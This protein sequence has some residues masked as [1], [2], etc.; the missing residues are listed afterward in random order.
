MNAKWKSI[1]VV[2]CRL[3]SLLTIFVI[4]SACRPS[5]TDNP[6]WAMS[7]ASRDSMAF[8]RKHHYTIGYNFLSITD[9]LFLYSYI[10]SSTSALATLSQSSLTVIKK[11]EKLVVLEIAR[12]KNDSTYWIKL[13]RD[14]ES[15]GWTPENTLLTS[16]TPCDPVSKLIFVISRYRV[17]LF[18]T[19][20]LLLLFLYSIHFLKHKHNYI[21]HFH[22]IDSIYP[23]L[24]C[25]L[26]ATTGC[27][28]GYMHAYLPDMSREFYFHPTL[29]PFSCPIP[30]CILIILLW[31][32]PIMTIAAIDDACHQLQHK[33]L[34]F[35]ITSLLYTGFALYLLFLHAAGLYHGYVLLPIYVLYALHRYRFRHKV[36][37][38]CGNC[39]SPIDHLGRCPQC[40]AINE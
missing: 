12:L 26:G 7:Q 9:T 29:N 34:F 5:K 15:A 33:H 20:I 31:L 22:D 2:G 14:Q 21:V 6:Y 30:L 39:S 27:F 28:H 16:V 4:T 35:Y 32:L 18:L 36:S 11:G 23:T 3:L 38:V 13:A 37:Y 8:A 40:G 25:I 19:S 10:P 1:R 17:Y 24:L